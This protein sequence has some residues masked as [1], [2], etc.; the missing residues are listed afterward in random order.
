MKF[1]N[2]I[3]ENMNKYIKKHIEDLERV[4]PEQDR[5]NFLRLD[6]NENP[7]GLPEDYFSNIISKI[8]PELIAMY[9]E[10]SHLINSL[11]K[12][13][14]VESENI[15]ITNGSD[16]AIKSIFEIF[17]ADNKKMLAVYPSFEMYS[18]YSKM[19]NMKIDL[20]NYDEDFSVD[21]LKICEKIDKDTAIISLL[22]PNN[23][24]GTVYKEEEVIEII[25]KA[26]KNNAI[27]IIDEAYHYFYDKSFLYLV[28][29][30]DNVVILRTFSKLCSI[31]GL[32]I[33][34]VV[35]STKMINYLEKIRQTFNVNSVGLYF[36]KSIIDDDYIID[37]LIKSEKDGK[38]YLIN[39]LRNNNYNYFYGNGN[40]VFIKPNRPIVDI[41]DDLKHNMILV[42]K[43]STP[44]LADYIRISTGDI[45]S[46]S[47]FFKKFL[48]LDNK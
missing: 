11:K 27:V 8:T 35:G 40:Y 3:N 36:A 24:I 32:R 47:K 28:K 6:M 33:G 22:N 9:P 1:F 41:V 7:I 44:I 16:E 34:Y 29:E 31:A 21:Y 43:Y 42:K 2:V 17:G 39:S 12:Y 18:V 48:E 45:N 38:D 26:K 15:M 25:Q 37:Y 23:P 5:I 20:V 10:P 19:Y 14:N 30:Y 13:L 46:M 4:R